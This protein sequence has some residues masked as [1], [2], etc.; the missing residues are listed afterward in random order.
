MG[1]GATFSLYLPRASRTAEVAAPLTSV[2]LVG[3]GEA[4]GCIL[5]V[6][7]NEAVG[8]FAADM[9]IELGYTSVWVPDAERALTILKDK[10]AAVNVVFSNI[11]MPGMSGLEFARTVRETY[12]S[13]AIVLTSGYSHILAEEGDHGFTVLQKPYSIDRLSR[14]LQNLL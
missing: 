8:S 4:E 1:V 5:V 14:L 3:V 11:I 2:A 9:L 13:L 10:S 12:P 7:D 6:E